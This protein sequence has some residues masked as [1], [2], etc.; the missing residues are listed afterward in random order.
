[1]AKTTRTAVAALQSMC[2]QDW[3]EAKRFLAGTGENWHER[4]LDAFDDPEDL[5]ALM[6]ENELIAL[7]VTKLAELAY[8]QTCCN[9]GSQT[10]QRRAEKEGKDVPGDS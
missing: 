1:M 2:D 5:I 9:M 8:M 3:E 10:L 7:G 6:Q 4:L